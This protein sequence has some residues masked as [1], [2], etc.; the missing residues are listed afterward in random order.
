ML[1]FP[2]DTRNMENQEPTREWLGTRRGQTGL[3]QLENKLSL[4][5]ISATKNT[6][7]CGSKSLWFL[8]VTL[9]CSGAAVWVRSRRRCDLQ[10]S[11]DHLEIWQC[12]YDQ[13]AMRC[14]EVMKCPCCLKWKSRTCD[15]LTI[16]ACVLVLSSIAR[17]SST[18]NRWKTH[19]VS[20]CFS[21]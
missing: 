16:N 7:L 4:C 21:S 13:K 2:Q 9:V 20:E 11:R 17:V 12:C 8:S 1:L 6:N 18:F 3:A 19:R 15:I 14:T 5:A 10:P